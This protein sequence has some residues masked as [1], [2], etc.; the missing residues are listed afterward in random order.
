MKSNLQIVHK[1]FTVWKGFW[2]NPAC[3]SVKINPVYPMY[4]ILFVCV[5]ARGWEHR[6]V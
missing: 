6:T 3:K 4:R 5:H 1:T 2:L